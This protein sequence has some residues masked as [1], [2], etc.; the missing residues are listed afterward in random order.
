MKDDKALYGETDIFGLIDT[1][2]K[3]KT[4]GINISASLETKMVDVKEIKKSA[5]ELKPFSFD[6]LE[7]YMI[8]GNYSYRIRIV[9][10]RI[11][12]ITMQNGSTVI[13]VKAW[14]GTDSMKIHSRRKPVLDKAKTMQN[15]DP[16]TAVVNDK[17]ECIG[18]KFGPVFGQACIKLKKKTNKKIGLNCIVS[19]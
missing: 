7:G 8:P 16:V 10:G 12:E 6:E 5:K 19:I 13:N 14:D 3:R 15:G 18:L 4:D 2:E 9:C 1:S 11:S 17:D